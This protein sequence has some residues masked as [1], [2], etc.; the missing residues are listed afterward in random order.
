M[1]EHLRILYIFLLKHK[2]EVS[3]YRKNQDGSVTIVIEDEIC[4][5]YDAFNVVLK[6]TEAK[7]WTE[8]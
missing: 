4:N 2:W 5:K 1:D 3:F 7:K 8:I 6:P